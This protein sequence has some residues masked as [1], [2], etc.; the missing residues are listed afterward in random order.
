MT[1]T[2]SDW[3]E[4]ASKLLDFLRSGAWVVHSV[5]KSEA[6]LPR[7]TSLSAIGELGLQDDP[8]GDYR[9]AGAASAGGGMV[10]ALKVAAPPLC[11][12]CA[13]VPS[14][15][16]CAWSY[17]SARCPVMRSSCATA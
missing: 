8:K 1:D 12:L 13:P 6:I 2:K 3:Q 17:I 5:E 11:Y 9:A 10:L 7:G 16:A 15:Y 14:A 4:Q